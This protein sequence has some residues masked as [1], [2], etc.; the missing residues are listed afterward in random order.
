MFL[1]S[2]C[3]GKNPALDQS[4]ALRTKLLSAELI[5][6]DVTVTAD[7]GDNIQI[8]SMECQADSHGAVHFAVT[9][10]ASISGIEGS[11]DGEKGA[12][13]FENTA[14]FFPLLADE[15]LTPVSAPWVLIQALRSGCI[16]SAGADG[17]T[18]LVSIDDRYDD[19]ALHLDVWLDETG[20]PCKAEILYRERKILS[21]DVKNFTYQ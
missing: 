12:L 6:F 15:Q 1:L 20:C 18:A 5:S 2:G 3:S 7:Y 16:T 4:V 21:L 10:P 11:I 14:L 13:E 9:A 17:D 8:F 19:D